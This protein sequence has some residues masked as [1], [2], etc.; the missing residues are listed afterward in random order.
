MEMGFPADVE[1][2]TR[3]TFNMFWYGVRLAPLERACIKS[4]I[5]HGH[6]VRVYTYNQPDLPEGAIRMDARQILP[7]NQ[8][9][10]FENSPSGFSNIFRY[11]LL[12][13]QGG[14][15]VDTD[16]VCLSSDIPECDYFWAEQVPGEIN[17][18]VLK[19]PA[20]DPRLEKLLEQSIRRSKH[21]QVWGQLGPHLLTEVLSGENLP[22][23]I[24]TTEMVYP[25]RFNEIHYLWLPEFYNTVEKR[26]ANSTFLHLWQAMFSRI[27]INH[28]NP[29]PEGSYLSK[30]FNT[31]EIDIPGP[32]GDVL[33]TRRLIIQYLIDNGMGDSIV[34]DLADMMNNPPRNLELLYQEI[35][36]LIFVTTDQQ[37]KIIDLENNVANPIQWII[38]ALR[39]IKKKNFPPGS[40]GAYIFDKIKKFFSPYRGK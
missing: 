21:L 16:V 31:Y 2:K 34:P 29:A 1:T 36:G 6:I 32:A 9:F 26:C 12:L 3:V 14:W 15:W 5:S 22:N 8:L 24:G 4:F 33:A 18:A 20:G 35:Q 40:R 17:G 27:G 25:I 11:K 23:H 38:F 10:I 37:K 7:E 39:K 13:E 30:L 28:K 19:F